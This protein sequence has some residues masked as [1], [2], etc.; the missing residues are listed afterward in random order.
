MVISSRGSAARKPIV[1]QCGG[2]PKAGA[3]AKSCQID[4]RVLTWIGAKFKACQNFLRRVKRR[5]RLEACQTRPLHRKIHSLR[6]PVDGTSQHCGQNQHAGRNYRRG[7]NSC[8]VAISGDRETRPPTGRTLDEWPSG[9]PG[10]RVEG[11]ESLR[12]LQYFEPTGTGFATKAF[13]LGWLTKSTATGPNHEIQFY[14]ERHPPRHQ[15]S[16]GHTQI[17]R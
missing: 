15:N 5:P 1:S 12:H 14:I 13:R 4:T 11:P 8:G 2:L 10:Q 7:R 9:H 16:A 3:G 17:G 6:C